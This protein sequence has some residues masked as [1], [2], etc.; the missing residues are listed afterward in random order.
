MPTTP[1]SITALPTAPDPN[2]RSTFNA[3]AYPWSAALNT[4]GTQLSAVAENV[5][6]N[7]D[8]G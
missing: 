5:K 8:H 3:R 1:P 4:F 6:A 2:D 7:A